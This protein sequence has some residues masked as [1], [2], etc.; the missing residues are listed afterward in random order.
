MQIIIK[1]E[2]KHGFQLHQIPLNFENSAAENIVTLKKPYNSILNYV[3]A[4]YHLFKEKN[5]AQIL[6]DMHD[7]ITSTKDYKHSF[8]TKK[9]EKTDA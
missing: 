4:Y 1:A 2:N 7:F 6:Q 8:Y 5:I 3:S 9:E